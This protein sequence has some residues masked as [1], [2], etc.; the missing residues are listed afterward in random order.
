MDE[1][2]SGKSLRMH[3]DCN[4]KS[5]MSW[6]TSGKH[7]TNILWRSGRSSRE[8]L[9][10]DPDEISLEESD[11]L[12]PMDVNH[13]VRTRTIRYPQKELDVQPCRS[14]DL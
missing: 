9:A 8:E 3:L 14:N 11:G 6:A 5:G 13:K 4:L 12:E 1:D 10:L 2:E 7:L